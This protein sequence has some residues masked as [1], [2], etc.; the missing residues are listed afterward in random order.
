MPRNRSTESSRRVPAARAGG[1]GVAAAGWMGEVAV[2]ISNGTTRRPDRVL[3]NC[4]RCESPTD[5]PAI[6]GFGTGTSLTGVT[7]DVQ[8]LK[9]GHRN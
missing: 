8:V 4:H 9:P 2:V 7:V 5:I 1:A 6:Q 3:E